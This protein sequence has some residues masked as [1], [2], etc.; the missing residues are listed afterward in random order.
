MVCA[1]AGP[2]QTEQSHPFPLTGPSQSLDDTQGTKSRQRRA[3]RVKE[4]TQGHEAAA[5]DLQFLCDFL[6][7]PLTLH[8][9]SLATTSAKR[10]QAL[11]SQR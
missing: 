3:K 7:H 9:W 6:Q 1:W 10:E 11:G 8:I 5:S 2:P 4:L